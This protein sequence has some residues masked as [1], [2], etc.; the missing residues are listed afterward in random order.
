M[1]RWICFVLMLLGTITPA[2]SASEEKTSLAAASGWC[3]WV[4][5]EPQPGRLHDSARHDAQHSL[6][7]TLHKTWRG[8]K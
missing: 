5:G 8:T 3:G 4:P 7:N 1:H 6:V 2:R